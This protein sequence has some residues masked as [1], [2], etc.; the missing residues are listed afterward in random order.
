MWIR[1][2]WRNDYKDHDSIC[3]LVFFKQDTLFEL[4][5][6][7]PTTDRASLYARVPRFLPV[8]L[9]VELVRPSPLLKPVVFLARKQLWHL[10]TIVHWQD[11]CHLQ[12]A[13]QADFILTVNIHTQATRNPFTGVEPS[14]YLSAPHIDYA[15]RLA[16]FVRM[17]SDNCNKNC[18][19]M[20]F[21]ARH[22]RLDVQQ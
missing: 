8:V 11:I 12:V 9:V 4:Q 3:L 15:S 16:T 18:C 17:T 14:D 7:P 6:E 1:H 19:I 10:L 22:S 2:T 21:Y 13:T 20:T 5:L